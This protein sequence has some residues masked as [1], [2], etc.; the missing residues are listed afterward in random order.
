[1]KASNLSVSK[2]RQF[3]HSKRS[4]TNF[5]LATRK[6]KRMKAFARFKIETWCI[7]LAYVDKLDKDN[8]GIRYLLV[9]QDLFD[10]AVDAKGMKTKNSKETACVFLTMITK[11]NRSEKNWVDKG[12][13]FAGE[14]KKLC[15]A[16]GIQLYSTMS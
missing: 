5:T 16:E 1:M 14:F 11:N 6:I 10:R 4:Y 12:T 3:L 15:K 13:E 7:D 8:N 9:R 2:V